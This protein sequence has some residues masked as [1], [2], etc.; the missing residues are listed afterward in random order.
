MQDYRNF[1]QAELE[2]KLRQARYTGDTHQNAVQHAILEGINA[3]R[4]NKR[5]RKQ[6]K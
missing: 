5:N 4:N 2:N 6:Q 3:L 1:I